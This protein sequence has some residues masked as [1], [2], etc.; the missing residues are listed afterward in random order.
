MTHCN[1]LIFYLFM[2]VP[3]FYFFFFFLQLTLDSYIKPIFFFL[4]SHI[5]PFLNYL[6]LTPL[7]H[8]TLGYFLFFQ[9]VLQLVLWSWRVL[10]FLFWRE[11]TCLCAAEARQLP[12]TLGLISTKMT[13][14]LRAVLQKRRPST[15][16]PSLMKDSTSAASLV[17]EHHQEA[18]CL[19]EVRHKKKYFPSCMARVGADYTWWWHRYLYSKYSFFE[20]LS[21]S[22]WRAPLQ[23]V[24]LPRVLTLL[25]IAVTILMLTPVLLVVGFLHIR[26]DNIA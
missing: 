13:S 23:W 17:L 18:G 24:R 15:V 25:W 6:Q 4:H 7:L 1:T 21:I 11:I 8:K 3:V 22:S 2:V 26:K 9:H 14:S 10:L 16:F 19:W 12:P 5:M 20:H